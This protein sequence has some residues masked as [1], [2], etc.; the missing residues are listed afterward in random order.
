MR[1]KTFCLILNIAK[2]FYS[3][4]MQT[5]CLVIAYLFSV[6]HFGMEYMKSFIEISRFNALLQPF[7][8]YTIMF[9]IIEVGFIGIFKIRRG[10]IL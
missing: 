2:R 6:V 8:Q 1:I 7:I 9:N 3:F 10:L 4:Y 5:K